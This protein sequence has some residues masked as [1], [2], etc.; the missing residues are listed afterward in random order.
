[1]GN[2]RRGVGR[3]FT[4]VL[5]V[6]LCA[7]RVSESAATGLRGEDLWLFEKPVHARL[8]AEAIPDICVLDL[9]TRLAGPG[10]SLLHQRKNVDVLP[11][12][13]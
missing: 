6:T 13:A 4:F 3:Q 2:H 7:V 11:Y 12:S 1:M 8:R 5:I 10:S 9:Q